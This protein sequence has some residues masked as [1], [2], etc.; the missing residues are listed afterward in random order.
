LS[1][2][3]LAVSVWGALFT[4]NAYWPRRGPLTMMF[5]FLAGWP[6]NE[7]AAFHIVWQ[8]LATVG[9]GIGGAFA[10][11]PGWLGLGITAVSWAGLMGLLG[12]SRRSGQE[13]E[14]ALEALLEWEAEV[15]KAEAE[16]PEET[17]Q[18]E[19]E[20]A[21]LRRT[22]TRQPWA[23]PMLMRARDVERV[24][25]LSY[26]PAGRRN[27]LDV[28]RHRDRPSGAPVL[29]WVHGGAWVVSQKR[30]QAMPMLQHMAAKGWMCVAINYRLS[31]RATFPDHLVDVKR[32]IA[33]IRDRGVE[34][35]ADPGFV[36][37]TGGSAGGHLSALAGLTAGMTEYQPGFE[38]TDT[39]VQ[40]C[41]PMYGIYD[42]TDRHN[43][44]GHHRKGWLWFL[45]RRVMKVTMADDPEAYAR[46]SPIEC[47]RPDAP[48]F[49]VIHGT[50]DNLVP[51]QEARHFV[52]ALQGVS[53]SPVLYIELHGATHGFDVFTST[54]TTHVVRAVERFGTWARTR[55]QADVE[56]P[57]V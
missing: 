5:S 33:W 8:A 16:T 43:L 20:E 41:V 21:A 30:H 17:A 3:F 54:R 10:D 13:V 25:N 9:F 7:A 1:W 12:R 39:S 29:L 38:D 24:A 22:A 50:H 18:A 6:T 48:P 55:H 47:V 11:W 36:L 28:Y 19:R 32:S 27:L 56:Q 15:A 40:A 34:L 31:P 23:G 57:R 53:E 4:L 2:A 26:G 37:V 52:G 42:L 46:A 45:E 44:R 35:G 14:Q 51:V 49:L